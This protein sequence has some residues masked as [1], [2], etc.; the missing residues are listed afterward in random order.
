MTLIARA[1]V[2]DISGAI[3]VQSIG[4][5]SAAL[6]ISP[7]DAAFFKRAQK[8]TS[9][10]ILNRELY[11]TIGR[12]MAGLILILLILY[13]AEPLVNMLVLSGV[14]FFFTILAYKE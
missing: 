7:M 1:F 6:W 2:T 5:F 12:L 13:T 10:L 9:S 3:L 14:L 4:A 11:L 8:Q